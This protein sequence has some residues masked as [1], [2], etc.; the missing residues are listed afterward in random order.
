MIYTANNSITV[1]RF[2]ET[3]W[4][5]EYT[6]TVHTWLDVYIEPIQESVWIAL[7]W[8]GAFDTFRLFS[9]NLDILIADKI[10]DKAGVEY[11][12]KWT[13]PFSSLVWNHVECL[14]Q[15]EYD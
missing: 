8:E 2:V 3:A 11:I 7:D 4:E 1:K 9:P 5:K 14:I 13:K 15:S 6:N 10:T 12:V